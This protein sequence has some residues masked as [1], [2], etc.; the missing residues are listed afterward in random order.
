MSSINPA[1]RALGGSK[2][3]TITYLAVRVAQDPAVQDACLR[4]ASDCATAAR[5]TS[6]AGAEISASW[7]RNGN[8]PPRPTSD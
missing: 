5:S 6:A 7:R 2:A 8:T 3:A 4:A 1:L